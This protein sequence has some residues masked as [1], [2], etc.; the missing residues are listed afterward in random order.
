MQAFDQETPRLFPEFDDRVNVVNS[1][2]PIQGSVIASASCGDDRLHRRHT[3]RSICLTQWKRLQRDIASLFDHLRSAAISFAVDIEEVIALAT[4]WDP[5]RH[6][7]AGEKGAQEANGVR[8][9]VV[10]DD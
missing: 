1:R 2:N 4:V 3:L 6:H 10:L 5:Q 7:Q 9:V 8:V